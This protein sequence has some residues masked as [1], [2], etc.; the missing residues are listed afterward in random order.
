MRADPQNPA[1]VGIRLVLVAVL[2]ALLVLMLGPDAHTQELSGLPKVAAALTSRQPL[3]VEAR[4]D[5][6]EAL[7]RERR[8]DRLGEFGDAAVALGWRAATSPSPR[9]LYKSGRKMWQALRR[10]D[11][12]SAVEDRALELVEGDVLGG[13]DSARAR[14]LYG[15]LRSRELEE[16]IERWLAG[17]DRALERGDLG[18]ARRR[19]K[20]AADTA[21]Q[22]RSGELN[23]LAARLDAARREAAEPPTLALADSIAPWE[24]EL[25]SALL[26]D[27]RDQVL[28][29]GG[30]RSDARL[31]HAAALYLDGQ[32]GRAFG[33]LRELGESAGV[34][35]GLARRWLE[36][37]RLNPERDELPETA[38]PRLSRL[39][40]VLG[41]ERLERHGLELSED[42]YDAW[43]A[44]LTPLN[45]ALAMPWRLLREDNAEPSSFEVLAV[46]QLASLRDGSQRGAAQSWLEQAQQRAAAPA[47]VWHDGFF[48][49]PRARTAY[50]RFALRPILVTEDALARITRAERGRGG[51]D[52]SFPTGLRLVAVGGDVHEAA[53]GFT[54]A[55]G[56]GLVGALAAGLEDDALNPLDSARPELLEAL[57]RLDAQ[58]RAGATLAVDPWDADAAPFHPLTA[59]SIFE[60]PVGRAIPKIAIERD[61]DSVAVR[62]DLVG[63]A[64]RC[65]A[66][67]VCIDRRH[68]LT[69]DVYA[70]VEDDGSFKLGAHTRLAEAHLGFEIGSDGPSVSMSLP[71]ARWLGVARW[72]P[73]EARLGVSAS[74]LDAAPGLGRRSAEQRSDRAFR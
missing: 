71:L 8:R 62:H 53:F 72:L 49:L 21:Q 38:P 18:M 32:R 9:R 34:A 33:E 73:L 28:A 37:P 60:H 48:V 10:L 41:G 2:T 4:V 51:I 23:A 14:A 61:R 1:R 59:H 22:D 74:G 26:L 68:A 50:A 15:R 66:D 13:S 24:A 44:A 12:R 47:E 16:R 11:D 54:R 43:K 30:D 45:L 65:P 39:L 70:V 67:S 42:A 52:M 46:A 6:A 20:H 3:D 56:L 7:L 64:A 58:L 27:R 17:A 35:A 31:A 19:L 29:L 25:C 57:R 5:E 69:G 36:D 55:Q 40:A 63:A